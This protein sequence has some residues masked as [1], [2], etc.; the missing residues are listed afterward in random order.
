MKILLIEDEPGI[1]ESVTKF[2][3]D[4]DCICENASS[5]KNASEKVNDYEYDLI[6]L[7]LMLP[8]G[9]GLEIFKELK[10]KKEIPGIIILS[11]KNSIDDKINGLELGADDYLPKPFSLPE[12]L[13]RVRSVYRR[14]NL[15]GNNKIVFDDVEIDINRKE[16]SIKNRILD[17][18]QKEFDVLL[19]FYINR[20][21]VLTKDSIAEHLWGD[22]SSSN[23][24]FDFIYQHIKN[25]RKKISEAGGKN[26]ISTVYGLGYK[27]NL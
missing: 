16:I 2:L 3:A 11:A 14:K 12:L 8:D 22:Y 19:Y 6:I 18:T 13:A 23:D 1:S 4:N 26:Y 17:L 25:L 10:N 20:G 7:D 27:F 24:H 9:N 21:K 15:S 5:L